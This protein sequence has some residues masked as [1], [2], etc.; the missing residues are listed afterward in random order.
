[1]IRAAIT[2]L[3]DVQY[4]EQ[5][6]QS[7]CA[8]EILKRL[9]VPARRRCLYPEVVARRT[10]SHSQGRYRLTKACGGIFHATGGNLALCAP[11]KPWVWTI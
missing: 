8:S 6:I 7:A 1:M 5:G 2:A 11:L 9:M 10:R 4:E 3:G